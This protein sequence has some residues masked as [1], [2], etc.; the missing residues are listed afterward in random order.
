MGPSLRSHHRLDRPQIWSLGH[1][2]LFRSGKIILDNIEVLTLASLY[3]SL[4][5]LTLIISNFL[6]ETISFINSNILFYKNRSSYI[7]NFFSRYTSFKIY[8]F[9]SAK[10]K[11]NK[12]EKFV[13]GKIK[14]FLY[15]QSPYTGCSMNPARSFGPAFWNSA[16]KDQWVSRK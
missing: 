11:D 16:W 2:H 14:L 15:F 13:I 10:Q 7:G 4:R 1:R 12:A 6:F 3:Y 5:Y 9:N 8:Y